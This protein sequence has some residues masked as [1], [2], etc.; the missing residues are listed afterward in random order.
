MDDRALSVA[1]N[2]HY[3]AAAAIDLL[4]LEPPFDDA[5]SASFVHQLLEHSRI[6]VTPHVGASTREAQR[7][8]GL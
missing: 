5:L 6:M 2:E 3:L 4:D 8:I 7:G 1:L